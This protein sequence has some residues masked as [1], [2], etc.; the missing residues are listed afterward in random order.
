MSVLRSRK[1]I[2]KKLRR[3]MRVGIYGGSFNPVTVAHTAVARYVLESTWPLDEVWFM[4]C[5]EHMHGK[6]LVSADHRLSMCKIA[7]SVCDRMSVFPY[8]IDYK[9]SGAMFRTI[10]LIYMDAEF[11]DI[12]FY[13]IVGA[14]CVNDFH[15]W[16]NFDQL[17]RI[18]KFIVV[19][20]KGV[21]PSPS[22]KGRFGHPHIYFDSDEHGF[23]N[24]HETSSTMI[25]E[26]IQSNIAETGDYPPFAG[27]LQEHLLESVYNYI[28]KHN[29]YFQPKETKK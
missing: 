6:N 12:E 4:P 5:Y 20:R 26:E 29:L 19:P 11:N 21:D 10:N 25:R 18:V 24:S 3:R 9:L 14:D 23:P 22:A 7:L 17:L 16:V 28:V 1:A 27:M 15:S 8:E 2:Y 13:L